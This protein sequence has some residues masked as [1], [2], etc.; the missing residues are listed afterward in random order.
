VFSIFCNDAT[1]HSDAV[2]VIDVIA[3]AI[4]RLKQPPQAK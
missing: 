1:G 3:G 4:A 2:R